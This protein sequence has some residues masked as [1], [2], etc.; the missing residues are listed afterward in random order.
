MAGTM[1]PKSLRSLLHGYIFVSMNSDSFAFDFHQ[2]KL[3]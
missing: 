2:T 1:W 3:Y